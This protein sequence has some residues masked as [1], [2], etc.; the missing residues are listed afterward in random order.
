MRERK[1]LVAVV[2]M[3]REHGD[4]SLKPERLAVAFEARRVPPARE[5]LQ[6]FGVGQNQRVRAVGVVAVS[7]GNPLDELPV[8]GRE[9]FLLVR[10]ADDEVNQVAQRTRLFAGARA[11]QEK[12]HG[13]AVTRRF[14]LV[15][16]RTADDAERGARRFEQRQGGRRQPVFEFPDEVLF[17]LGLLGPGKTVGAGVRLQFRRHGP[18]GAEKKKREF[19]QARLALRVQQ[20]RPPVRVRKI[21]ARERQFFK[22][23]LQ[24]QPRAL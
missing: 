20:A 2:Q 22:I 1:F 9:K 21:A 15:R 13:E 11:Q 17:L 12:L 4:L 18:L 8:G 16:L 7:V 24:Q 6:Q 3:R 23:I 14:L 10:G 5:P 19:L